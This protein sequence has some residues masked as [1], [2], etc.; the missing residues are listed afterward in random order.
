[1]LYLL[2]AT[3]GS[4]KSQYA[5]E[6]FVLDAI[7]ENEADIADWHKNKARQDK[8]PPQRR[9]VFC[10]I[11]GLTR[12]DRVAKIQAM[13]GGLPVLDAPDDW[14]QCPDGSMVIYDEAQ[15]KHLFRATGT[16][17][18]PMIKSAS[19]AMVEDERITALDTHRHRGFDIVLI[20]Q[21]TGLIHHWAK[22]FVGCHI[23]LERT[24]GAEMMTVRE[25]GKV[26]PNPAD[27]FAR[28]AADTSLRM[29]HKSTWELYDS[30]TIHTHKFRVP[31][32]A[33]WAVRT[34][35]ALAILIP[36]G[37]FVLAKWFGDD[38]AAAAP[39]DAA[40]SDVVSASVFVPQL[41]APAAVAASGING[42]AAGRHC[43]CW[44]FAGQLMPMDEGTCRN[45]AEGV[46][47]MPLDLNRFQGGSRRPDQGESGGERE[48]PPAPRAVAGVR[49][50]PT[51][52][53]SASAGSVQ[54]RAP[55][56]L[57]ASGA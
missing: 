54:G 9:Q 30:A 10:N 55:E 2:T 42:C 36:L 13:V 24:S 35:L 22:K 14:R 56:T 50:D 29:M 4:G 12:P 37:F 15:Q 18:V 11:K 32:G 43:R 31:A 46:I 48:A 44:D 26:Q 8:P 45:Y 17:G 7:R 52:V 23:D 25:W 39:A 21:E 57:R 20:T 34:F 1:M 40:P 41:P 16:P 33:K 51:T 53:G 6:R 28:E 49:T 19:G 38:A 3:P 5:I 47:P 27:H